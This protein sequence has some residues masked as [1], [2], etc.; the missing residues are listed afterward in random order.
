MHHDKRNRSIIKA[1]TYRIISIIFDST[2]AFLV[3]QS[4]EKTLILVVISN[5]FSIFM[6]FAHERVWNR[7]PWGKH[8]IICK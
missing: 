6:Y 4:A 7:I 3:T 2:V 8:V 1:I 5:I